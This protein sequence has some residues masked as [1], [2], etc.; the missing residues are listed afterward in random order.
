MP[1]DWNLDAAG[2]VGQP[3]A[4]V[5]PTG[6]Q[7]PQGTA[8]TGPQGNQGPV[9]PQGPQ[10]PAGVSGLNEAPPSGYVY[11]R[12]NGG[13]NALVVKSP[14]DSM[15]GQFTS[16]PCHSGIGNPNGNAAPIMIYGNTYAAYVSFLR[17]GAFGAYFGLDYDN[18]FRVG[19]WSYG[20]NSYLIWTG[21]V[22]NPYTNM[23]LV[24]AGDAVLPSSPNDGAVG[25][26][27]I[28]DCWSDGVSQEYVRCRY[29]Q[30]ADGYG[31]WA[32]VGY[33]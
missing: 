8:P 17:E 14:S 25:S 12:M 5:G 33:A 29:W 23:R 22:I 11:G 10:G 24:Y 15:T 32:T 4:P 19:G 26:T 1:N 7:G 30:V 9:G 16:S 18:N 21:Y 3:L 20:G 2:L 28:T 13:W 31:N 6:P 27:L